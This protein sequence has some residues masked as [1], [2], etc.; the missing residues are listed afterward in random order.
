MERS[1]TA[2]EAP[3]L[4]ASPISSRMRFSGQATG[5]RTAGRSGLSTKRQPRQR[6]A[7]AHPT[8]A[9]L[10]VHDL[11]VD[12]YTVQLLRRADTPKLFRD[13][14]SAHHLPS[15]M[16]AQNGM[17]NVTARPKAIRRGY[18]RMSLITGEASN[19]GER[20]IIKQ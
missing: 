7:Q 9:G 4:I 12:R 10:P 19:P 5:P 18:G 6:V 15:E 11:R 14:V 2:T 3:L 8:D 20:V 1:V 17:P 13:P 16:A